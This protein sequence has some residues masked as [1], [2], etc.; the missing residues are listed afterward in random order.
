M[1]SCSK[2]FPFQ[3]NIEPLP[4][5]INFSF[6]IRELHVKDQA[7]KRRIVLQRLITVSLCFSLFFFCKLFVSAIHFHLFFFCNTKTSLRNAFEVDVLTAST[8]H[9]CFSEKYSTYN[10][11]VVSG[12][13]QRILHSGNSWASFSQMTI[14]CPRLRCSQS[15]NF[16]IEWKGIK[17]TKHRNT[18]RDATVQ[19]QINSRHSFRFWKLTCLLSPDVSCHWHFHWGRGEK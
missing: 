15:N 19:P 14:H 6:A 4:N 17:K 3:W 8:P 11:L 10:I 9:F 18:F 7:F 2:Y 5:Y 1:F 13:S 12:Y 16:Q